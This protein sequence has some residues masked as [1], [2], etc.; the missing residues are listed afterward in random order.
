MTY[1][2]IIASAS[3]GAGHARAASALKSAFD[4]VGYPGSA[5]AVDTL[6]YMVPVFR[7]LYLKSYFSVIGAL[8]WYWRFLYRRWDR[9]KT[10]GLERR[11][12]CT[13]DRFSA[14]KFIRLIESEQP[15]HVACTHFLPAEIL[16]WM[17][18]TGR[19]DV[20]VGVVVTDY[21]AHRIWMNDGTDQYFVA[22]K[23]IREQMISKGA[24]A[25]RVATFG[26]PI[27]PV[28]CESIDRARARANLG[29]DPD[30]PTVLTLGGGDGMGG[31]RKTVNALAQCGT[32]QILAVAGNNRK[33]KR[34]LDRLRFDGPAKLIP[35]GFVNNI[36]TL[37]AASN[38]VVTKPG[39]MS[40]T[41]CLAAGVPMVLTLPI[42]GQEE[43]NSAFLV[44]CGAAASASDSY[45]L[46][47]VVS[48]LLN[49]SERLAGMSQAAR[50]AAQPRAAFDIVDALLR[51]D[52]T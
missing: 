4:A 2:L 9:K 3:A 11:A 39:G 31:I 24:P 33:L 19:L 15:T 46:R 23:R 13:M 47:E 51:L 1:K 8:P 14:K 22:S 25:S 32:L 20:P 38:L 42:P 40:G 37:M 35:Y 36:E 34:Q 43:K 41:E 45:E 48:A 29:L 7:Q 49:D 52:A 6:Q 16:T 27:D 28:F 50:D 21:D 26:I 17:R 10:S 18:R 44:E 30:L 12:M 5:R